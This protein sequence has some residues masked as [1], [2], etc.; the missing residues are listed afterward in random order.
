MTKN[1]TLIECDTKTCRSN[2]NG[3]CKE[4]SIFIRQGKCGNIKPKTLYNVDGSYKGYSSKNYV[5]E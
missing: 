4:S 1:I 5:K 2:E 3:Q